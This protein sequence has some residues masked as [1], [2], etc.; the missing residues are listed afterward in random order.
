MPSAGNAQCATFSPFVD[1][2]PVGSR[3]ARIQEVLRRYSSHVVGIT[4]LS[5]AVRCRRPPSV[6]AVQFRGERR[7][8]DRRPVVD[9][10][11]RGGG[12]LDRS[13]ATGVIARRC[14]ARRR[15]A[16][17]ARGAERRG[18]PAVC[19]PRGG[20][21]A[22]RAARPPRRPRALSPGE[23]D[24]GA[25]VGDRVESTTQL[26]CSHEVDRTVTATTVRT[27]GDDHKGGGSQHGPRPM[28]MPPSRG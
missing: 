4:A 25:A 2:C 5:G 23:V 15:R 16:R 18:A 1:P 9:R 14:R 28:R 17:A 12:Q 10:V 8:G 6:S 20:G 13:V 24:D 19:R 21:G 26:R 7:V 3:V 22:R 27:W 11:V